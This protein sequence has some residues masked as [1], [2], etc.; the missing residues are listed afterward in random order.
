MS[1][2]ALNDIPHTLNETTHLN[3]P[4]K[5]GRWLENNL[6][7]RRHI[8]SSEKISR[9]KPKSNLK[10]KEI[11]VTEYRFYKMERYKLGGRDTQFQTCFWPCN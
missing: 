2:V 1:F 11:C 6:T 9:R 5:E 10:N 3:E 4:V 7:N 8:V